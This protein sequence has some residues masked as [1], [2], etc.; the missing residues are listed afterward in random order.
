MR[1]VLIIVLQKTDLLFKYASQEPMN[2]FKYLMKTTREGISILLEESGDVILYVHINSVP[3]KQTRKDMEP[4]S[5]NQKLIKKYI[6]TKGSKGRCSKNNTKK[7]RL[8]V[9]GNSI[10]VAE[11]MRT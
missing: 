8:E 9:A 7:I 2:I 11:E 10:I 3:K 1:F 5:S 4:E 6:A